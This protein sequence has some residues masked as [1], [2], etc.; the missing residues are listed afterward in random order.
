MMSRNVN[1]R[2]MS[3]LNGFE[4]PHIQV[5]AAEGFECDEV[6]ADSDSDISQCSCTPEIDECDDGIVRTKFHE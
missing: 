1:L 5:T 3:Y 2:K 6:F 4:V